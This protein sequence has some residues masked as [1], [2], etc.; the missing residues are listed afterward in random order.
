MK[1]LY[2]LVQKVGEHFDPQKK[3]VFSVFHPLFEALETFL[4]VKPKRTEGSVHVRDAIDYK[5]MMMHVCYALIPCVIA[6]IYNTGYQANL[7]MEK[8]GLTEAP[9]WRGWVMTHINTFAENYYPLG[10]D[11]SNILACLV[12]GAL[13]FLP[14]YIVCMVVGGLW[15]VLFAIVHKHDVNEGFFVTG[16]LFPLTLPATIPLWQ[17][18]IGISF[19][20]VVGKEIFG[21]TG[22]NFFNPALTG[23]V[24]L[25][26]AHALQISGDSVWAAVDWDEVKANTTA[27]GI[28]AIS[29][30]TPLS[31]AMNTNHD[32]G[33]MIGLAQSGYTW[34]DSFIGRIPGSMGETSTLAC[35]IG[36]VMLLAF[37]I[38]SW[39][40]MLSMTLGAC[41]LILTLNQIGSDTNAAFAVPVYWHLVLGGFAFGAIFMATDPVTSS[42]THMG[43]Y[44]YGA[45]IGI[46]VIVIRVLNPAYPEGVM[47]AILLGNVCAPLID[48]YIV[49][50][51]IQ[52]RAAR[53]AES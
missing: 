13:Y 14:I 50:A 8:A 42:M 9:G 43:Q 34:M 44:I 36:M 41:A 17:V 52:R 3:G 5:R 33:G 18:A 31:V 7:I 25:F 10:F 26:F 28:D 37:G 23:R 6:A 22:R 15:E 30:A 29:G 51:N 45:I 12:H 24:Y 19:G 4:F 47:L 21:G 1:F 49:K 32:Q 53:V 38:A 11:P 27:Q 40:I 39:R 48:Y 2:N 35:L 20:V 46:L 16:L